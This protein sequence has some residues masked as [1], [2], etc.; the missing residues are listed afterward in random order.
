ML[1]GVKYLSSGLK[2]LLFPHVCE[3]CGDS[4]PN[5]YSFVC[6]SCLNN[7]FETPH[8][9]NVNSTSDIML[10]EGVIKQF[11]MWRFDK[12]GHLQDLLHNLKY[13]QLSGVGIDLGK[14][15][16][17]VLIERTELEISDDWLLIPV[18]LHKKKEQKRGYNQARVIAE[19]IKKTTKFKL[20]EKGLTQRIKNTETQTG[21]T[22][23]RRNL[24]IKNAFQIDNKEVV[25]EQ[26]CII[27]DDVFTTG[28]TT[29][30]LANVLKSSGAGKIMIATVA[31]A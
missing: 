30:E 25:E 2:E 15:L 7:S 29:F 24:N 9:N 17:K 21:F 22:L 16:G 1:S 6:E 26:N 27:I 3:L 19:G 14:Q 4:L 31:C 8:S 23:A 10:P 12:G 18:P 28:A 5:T 13:H 11:A 20:I